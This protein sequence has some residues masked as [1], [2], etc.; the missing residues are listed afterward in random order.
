MRARVQHGASAG[1]VTRPVFRIESAE[2]DERA[3]HR[4]E[5]LRDSTR[6][7]DEEHEL[8]ALVAAVRRWDADHAPRAGAQRR[9]KP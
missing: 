3:R 5:S 2:D 8:Q 9:K 6:S 4:I 1:E 7:E